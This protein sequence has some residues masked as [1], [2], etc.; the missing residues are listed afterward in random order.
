MQYT[1]IDFHSEYP[2]IL[3]KLAPLFHNQP[4]PNVTDNACGA[5]SRMILANATAVP[6]DQ[7]LPVLFEALP[8]KRDYLEYEAVFELIFELYQQQ[9]PI[10]TMSFLSKIVQVAG[11]ALGDKI[12]TKSL[13]EET[14]NRLGEFVRSIAQ[15]NMTAFQELMGTLQQNEQ[16]ALMPLLR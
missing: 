4:W 16:H 9:N 13:K 11:Q 7:V 6:L 2:A 3:T 5:V 14:V 1:G 8:L 15:S 12:V 10:M